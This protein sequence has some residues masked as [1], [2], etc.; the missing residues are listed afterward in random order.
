MILFKQM[1]RFFPLAMFLTKWTKAPIG[2][3][4]LRQSNA[5]VT[6]P[7]ME[8]QEHIDQEILLR[9]PGHQVRMAGSPWDSPELKKWGVWDSGMFEKMGSLQVENV[10]VTGLTGPKNHEV[11]W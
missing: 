7:R 11:N 1:T 6:R 8:D 3:P 5:L 2:L 10:L 9:R 4:G